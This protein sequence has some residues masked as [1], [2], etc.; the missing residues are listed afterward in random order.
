M[1][2]WKSEEDEKGRQ[3]LTLFKEEENEEMLQLPN[4]ALNRSLNAF[5]PIYY[6]LKKWEEDEEE[7][8]SWNDNSF[9]WE[10]KNR[11]IKKRGK[12]EEV[13]GLKESQFSKMKAI[14]WIQRENDINRRS[15]IIV[16]KM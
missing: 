16:S 10:G 12:G 2:I 1:G 4:P 3:R 9:M 11:G 5:N 13:N 6:P 15:K 7:R 14:K 8:E